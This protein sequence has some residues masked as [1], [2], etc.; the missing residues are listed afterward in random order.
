[1]SLN[2]YSGTEICLGF[3]PASLITTMS[4]FYFWPEAKWPTKFMGTEIILFHHLSSKSSVCMCIFPAVFSLAET[5]D[6]VSQS[7]NN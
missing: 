6:L 1:M 4:R 5:R 3:V 2:K 7:M